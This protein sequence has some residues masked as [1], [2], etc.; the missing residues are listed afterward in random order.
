[1]SSSAATGNQW[2]LDGKIIDGATG[3]T[4]NPVRSGS[5]TVSVVLTGGCTLLSDNFAFALK[6]INPDKNTEIGLATF[7]VPASKF[8][9]VLF[10]SKTPE[11]LNLYL[12]NSAGKIVYT[13]SKNVPAGNFSTSIDVSRQAPGTYTVRVVLGQKDYS[14]KVI[15]IP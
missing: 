4:Y 13:E 15:I 11:Q 10:E 14:H 8:L 12:I 7:P 5:Y 2:Y 6:A 3:Q 1:L 9:N